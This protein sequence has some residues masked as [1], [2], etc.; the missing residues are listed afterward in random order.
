MPRRILI[1]GAALAAIS[2][3]SA[4]VPAQRTA[5][6]AG[7]VAVDKQLTS[8]VDRTAPAKTAAIAAAE[9]GIMSRRSDWWRRRPPPVAKSRLTGGTI[10]KHKIRAAKRSGRR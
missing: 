8:T 5:P 7:I 3:L 10:K 1:A 2:A 9:V 4:F 6:L